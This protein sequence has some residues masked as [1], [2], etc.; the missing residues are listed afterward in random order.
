[1]RRKEAEQVRLHKTEEMAIVE[2]LRSGFPHPEAGVDHKKGKMVRELFRPRGRRTED[3]LISMCDSLGGWKPPEPQKSKKKR[4]G[5][6][7]RGRRS[8]LIHATKII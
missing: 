1:M 6:G 3:I 2:Q 5:R 7:R 8:F 4:G